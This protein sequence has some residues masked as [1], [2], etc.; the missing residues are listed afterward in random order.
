[1]SKGIS[2]I[3]RAFDKVVKA[4]GVKKIWEKTVPKGIRRAVSKTWKKIRKPLIAA[5]AIYLTAGLGMAAY[6]AATG[7]SAGFAGSASYGFGAVNSAIG[8][9]GGAAAT[10]TATGAGAGSGIASGITSASTGATTAAATATAGSTGTMAA[11]VTGAAT[12]TAG[13]AATA[14]AGAGAG[15]GGGLL[16]KAASSVGGYLKT[17]GGGL[18]AASA[19]QGAG[20]YAQQRSAQKREDELRANRTYWGMD[21]HGNTAEQNNLWDSIQPPTLSQSTTLDDLIRRRR[22]ELG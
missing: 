21:G 13:S 3:G 4:T 18:L 20:G 9:G 7:A 6:G 5:A 2:K 15:A 14:G 17:T 8:I 10:T 19:L 22:E 16:S 12:G 1:M 11:G